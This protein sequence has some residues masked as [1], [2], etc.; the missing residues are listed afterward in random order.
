MQLELKW[1]TVNK[2]LIF[3]VY[4][5]IKKYTKKLDSIWLIK[6]WDVIEYQT[7]VF[8]LAVVV[9][10]QKPITRTITLNCHKI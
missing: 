6:N 1:D 4:F 3:S 7:K 2:S 10:K 9:I 5:S 8:K